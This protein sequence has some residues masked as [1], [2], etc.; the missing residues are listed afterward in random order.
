MGGII[1]VAIGG[2][3]LIEGLMWAMAP[4]AMRR[5]YDEMMRQVTDRDLHIG[6]AVAVFIGTCVFMI[7]TKLI[8]Q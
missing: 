2:F 7:G 5:A 3:I 8:L 1:L 6:G 4:T